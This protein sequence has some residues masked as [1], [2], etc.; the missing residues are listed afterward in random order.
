MDLTSGSRGR[1]VLQA[2]GGQKERIGD[3]HA[4][5]TRML[6]P[7]S[8][9]ESPTFF[10]QH[11]LRMALL[12]PALAMRE[13]SEPQKTRNISTSIQEKN[14]IFLDNTPVLDLS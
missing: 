8:P 1:K 13:A 11:C 14:S 6:V 5:L 9:T 12:P 10:W 7:G 3:K 2:R 4:A